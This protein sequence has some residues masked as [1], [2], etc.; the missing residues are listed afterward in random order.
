MVDG[1]QPQPP[2]H[3]RGQRPVLQHVGPEPPLDEGHAQTAGSLHEDEGTLLTQ[4][5]QGPLQ[6]F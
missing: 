2:D 5:V 6:I 1:A 4:C 3:Q